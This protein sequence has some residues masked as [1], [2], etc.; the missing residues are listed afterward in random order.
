[1]ERTI[2]TEK[3]EVDIKHSVAE[4]YFKF[5]KFILEKHNHLCRTLSNYEKALEKSRKISDKPSIILNDYEI[6]C[7]EKKLQD[8]W[9]EFL[10]GEIG[11]CELRQSAN[12]YI[13]SGG[14]GAFQTANIVDGSRTSLDMT[15]CS[16][17]GVAVRSDRLS[18][19]INNHHKRPNERIQP[20]DYE[21]VQREIYGDW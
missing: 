17:C 16:H 9:N 10:A 7:C 5:R 14:E 21:D 2:I 19:H 13:L 12:A 4:R 15:K 20:I 8:T 3:K 6:N 1:M 18:K 11:R